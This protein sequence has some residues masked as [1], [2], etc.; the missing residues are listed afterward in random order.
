V[1]NDYLV[2][3]GCILVGKVAEMDALAGQIRERPELLSD[4][5]AQLFG[6]VIKGQQ[7]RWKDKTIPP[8][9][10]SSGSRTPSSTGATRRA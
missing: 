4:P 5:D 1:V 6:V 8:C 2:Y 3:E 7:Y 9:P 10:T